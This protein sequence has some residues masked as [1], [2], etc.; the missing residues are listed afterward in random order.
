MP[1]DGWFDECYGGRLRSISWWREG[2]AYG[3]IE[4]D[5]DPSKGYRFRVR[6]G[7]QSSMGSFVR[8]ATMA[9]AKEG[10]KRRLTAFGIYRETPPPLL[11]PTPVAP[12]PE[13][14]PAVVPEKPKLKVRTLREL[15][16]VNNALMG[17]LLDTAARLAELENRV[18][19]M[20]SVMVLK[21]EKT[22]Q[23]ENAL[24]AGMSQA[25]T[26]GSA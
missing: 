13:P 4:I 21:D 24:T 5:E 25:T 3:R 20:L 2:S 14:A 8:V 23:E 15:E 9:E 1:T 16:D 12:Q 26:P 11:V 17:K 18:Q 19:L 22:I 10:L 6:A 7:P